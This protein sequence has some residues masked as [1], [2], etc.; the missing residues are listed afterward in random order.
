MNP[1]GR[2]KDSF[3]LL[4]MDTP[5]P[6]TTQTPFAVTVSR[7]ERLFPK[8]TPAQLA[9]ITSHGRRRATSRSEVLVDVGDRPRMADDERPRAAKC[10]LTSAIGSCRALSW[11]RAR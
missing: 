3:P 9:R 7:P 2:Q 6:V 10:W 1:L 4:T 8:L 11:S 5:D